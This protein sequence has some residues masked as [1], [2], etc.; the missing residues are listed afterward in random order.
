MRTRTHRYSWAAPVAVALIGLTA[1]TGGGSSDLAGASS[2]DT[3]AAP[4]AAARETS[5]STSHGGAQA[6]PG[7][8]RTRSVVKTGEIALTSEDLSKVR[9]EVDDLLAAVGG[10]VD[11]EHTTNDEDG[12][13]DRSAL[14][15][16]VPVDRFDA[17]KQALERLGTLEY[18]RESEKD[19]TTEVIDTAERV[20]TLENSLDRLQRFQRTAKDVDDLIRYEQQITTRQ[21]ELQSL[22]AQQAYL[23]DRTGMSTIKLHLATPEK[24]VAP[25]R[26]LE[27]AGF[28]TGL[29]S[30]WRALVGTVVV[31]VT[32]LG[33]VL[34]FAVA[35]T[36]LGVPAWVALRTLLRRRRTPLPDAP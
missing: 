14:T 36:V 34:P 29:S 20:Q 35:F 21:A 7:A 25:E 22:E 6:L 24:Y 33:A 2:A 23:A 17:A 9:G 3:A 28:V 11:K 5:N 16:R 10:S 27:D 12:R 31:V 19:V 26:I 18:S 1:C 15:L 4:A 32:V 8:V 13:V 30:G